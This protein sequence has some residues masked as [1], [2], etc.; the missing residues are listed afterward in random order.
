MYGQCTQTSDF[1]K[2]QGQRW[3]LGNLQEF[4]MG[5]IVPCSK[6]V[7]G[8]FYITP[9]LKNLTQAS[10]LTGSKLERARKLNNPLPPS[11]PPLK[12]IKTMIYAILEETNACKRCFPHLKRCKNQSTK[13]RVAGKEM[14]PK[15]RQSC[16]LSIL[17]WSKSAFFVFI[18]KCLSS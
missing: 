13:Q 6:N 7:L 16:S 14:W 15:Q 17:M 2:G 11:L 5:G 8:S 1:C 12:I 18:N 9:G 4:P 10:I 3:L